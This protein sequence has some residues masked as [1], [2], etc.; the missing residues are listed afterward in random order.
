MRNLI[1]LTLLGSLFSFGSFAQG[2]DVNDLIPIDELGTGTYKNHQ[3]GLYP[4]GSNEMPPDFYNDAVEMAK[5]V[6][7][8]NT[9]GNPDPNG[10]IGVIGLGASTVAMFGKGLEDQIPNTAGMDRS[11]EYIN[12]GIGAQ[13]LSKI[14][15][16]AT[17]FW[18]TI[19][20]RVKAKGM[21]LDQVQVLWIEED[22]LRNRSADL[23]VRG[24]Q[25]LNDFIY[26][27]QFTKK[28]YPNLR[29]FYVSGRH[30]T[31][32]MPAEAKD[33]HSE[34][35]PYINGWVCKWLIEKQI[36]GDKELNYIGENAVAPLILWG[37]Y[38]W[39]QGDKPR[40]DGYTWDASLLNSDGI[41]PNEAGIK[42]VAEDYIHFWKTDP[43]S[44]LWFLE[45]PG[46]LTDVAD[47]V[48]MNIVI[49]NTVL[50][51]YAQGEI[52]DKFRMTILKDSV[53]VYN[54]DDET[55]ADNLNIEL[56]EAGN[57]KYVITDMQSR[58]YA[59]GFI[60]NEDLSVANIEES[61]VKTKNK[62]E[63][64]YIDPNAPAWVVNG[65]NKL[66]K[67]K[68][69]LNGHSNVKVVVSDSNDKIVFEET[70]ILNK[71]TNLNDQLERG[72]YKFR[73]Y[74]ED[75]TE[76]PLP[77]EFKSDVRIKF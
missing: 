66:P 43:V 45:N 76:I 39:T 77:E 74:D 1:L 60:V 30:T 38:F 35:K 54:N 44:Q 48:Y 64:A 4:N 7:P 9:S 26:I 47:L 24:E 46:T 41:H 51:K 23:D 42:K 67:L 6:Q 61:I 57:Y 36:N 53:V 37:P 58:A 40:K 55:F 20:Q 10:K 75:G 71:H 56:K 16:P 34:P 28:H 63:D 17:N 3:G 70:D 22:N 14:M 62:K 33:K 13:D 50:N 8:L 11:I 15:D 65:N 2:V 5:S 18:S 31:V 73:F 68:R 27:V 19:D 32:F 59:A 52:S 12:G 49:N 72:D 21:S 69:I 29:L 25:L